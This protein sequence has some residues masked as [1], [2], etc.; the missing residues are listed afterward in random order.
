MEAR[1]CADELKHYFVGN[2]G[3]WDLHHGGTASSGTGFR[4]ADAGRERRKSER[5]PATG[6]PGAWRCDVFENAR[7]GLHSPDEPIRPFRGFKWIR[8]VSRLHNSPG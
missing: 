1:S 6:D 5:N 3:G 2:F 7:F 4:S 8:E